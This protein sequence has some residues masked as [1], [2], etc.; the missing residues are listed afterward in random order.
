MSDECGARVDVQIFRFRVADIATFPDD[1][2]TIGPDG[3][4]PHYCDLPEGHKGRHE[5]RA[6]GERM[7]WKTGR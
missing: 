5:T 4:E 2:G 3:Y 6:Y 7:A 1:L